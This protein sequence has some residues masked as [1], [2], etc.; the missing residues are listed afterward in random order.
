[1]FAA[2]AAVLWMLGSFCWQWFGPDVPPTVSTETTWVVQPLTPE[3]LPDFEAHVRRLRAEQFANQTN[4]FED[5]WFAMGKGYEEHD[6]DVAKFNRRTRAT[7]LP[8]LAFDP[9]EPLIRRGFGLADD[10]SGWHADADVNLIDLDFA[11]MRQPWTV[12]DFDT[13][14]DP[15]ALRTWWTRADEKIQALE[16]AADSGSLVFPKHISHPSSDVF[17]V[18]V[19]VDATHW[20]ARSAMNHLAH[21]RQT[22][23]WE[24]IK[25]IDRL[26]EFCLESRP[27]NLR[28]LF[29]FN[30][31][32]DIE[33]ILLAILNDPRTPIGL[34]QSIDDYL[35]DVEHE[36]KI[37][38]RL[39]DVY[40]GERL[41]MVR[42]VLNTPRVRAS[43]GLPPI[44]GDF[45]VDD[46]DAPHHLAGSLD[47]DL[48]L[49]TLNEAFDA[50]DLAVAEPTLERKVVAAEL[51]LSDFTQHRDR[52]DSRG[53]T[54]SE[55]ILRGERTLAWVA[56]NFSVEYLPLAIETL[57]DKRDRVRLL[58]LANH[59]VIEHRSDNPFPPS[60][61]PALRDRFQLGPTVV[62]RS[63][64]G[65]F[66]LQL[67]PVE[68]DQIDIHGISSF[69]EGL[70]VGFVRFSL[71]ELI[72]DFQQ[73][74]KPLRGTTP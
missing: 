51:A 33:R 54:L 50:I 3:G 13:A 38:S 11:L 61:S 69:D 37:G 45:A 72:S 62:Y 68:P 40:R 18:M 20:L 26:I 4:G 5:F 6:D 17:E 36:C 27:N 25:R 16:R 71:A 63:D 12:A 58:R 74:T 53:P 65:S 49:E 52:L 35:S 70:R 2:A 67:R 30:R 7:L 31:Y 22:Q 46:L 9:S 21:G 23:A 41:F 19:T 14:K 42:Y 60:L 28:A 1:M 39:R 48:Y 8:T 64:G 44:V 56:H 34:L 59:L 10:D 57:L 32:A 55:R 15:A 24:Q 47:W 29:A 73:Q 43:L 66:V